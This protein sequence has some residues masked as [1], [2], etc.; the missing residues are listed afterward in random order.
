MVVRL[1]VAGLLLALGA[2][3]A[4]AEEL[5]KRIAITIDD[6]PRKAGP[7]MD[8]ECRTSLL[9]NSLEA[10]GITGA[11]FFV[12]TGGLDARGEEGDTRLKRYIEAG[13]VIANHTHGHGSANRMSAEDFIADVALAKHKLSAYPNAPYFRFPYLREGDNPAKRDAIRDGLEEL[14]LL[15]GYVTVDNYDWYLQALLDEAVRANKPLDLDAWREVYVE[16][17]TTEI[18][19]YDNIAVDALGRSPAHVL[20]LHE[21][22]LAALFIDDLAAALRADGWE[23]I[24]ALEAYE[25]PIAQTTPDTML[26]NQGRVSA[27]AHIAG[28]PA[29][30]LSHPWESRVELRALLVKRG[31]VD[32]AEG[33]YLEQT[34]PGI[35]PEVFA[36]GIV[37]LDDRYEFGTTLSADG[38]EIFFGTAI[39]D[40]GEIWN[41]RH[42]D[43]AWTTPEVMLSNPEYPYADPMLSRDRTRL[44]FISRRPV[45]GDNPN[46]SSDIWYLQWQSDGWSE[47]KHLGAPINTSADEF[48]VSF[49]DDG[50]FVFSSNRHEPDGTNFDL[51]LSRLTGDGFEEPQALQGNALTRAYEADPFIA[52][53]GSYI[54]FSSTR[55]SGIG[56][57]DIY[58]TFRQDDGSWSRSVNLGD[59]VNT[60]GN[61]FCPFVTRDGRF[62]F[63]TSNEDIFWVDAAVIEIARQLLR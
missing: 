46:S 56:G 37:S 8:A 9:I 34:S 60:S 26:L 18:A 63:Y 59:G 30:E 22:D 1:L 36:P 51:Y 4:S 27:L 17:L 33:A 43:G 21:N 39:D 35:V 7:L 52:P 54:L 25:D 40:R 3:N 55:R 47:P 14:G 12:T 50:E 11:M 58:A 13:H 49:T 31:M 2:M 53:D 20:L 10:A 16:V 57:R 45:D 6:A 24:P 44:Y 62:L 5:S 38:R 32:F 41:S 29:R 48:F 61:D 15:Q 42:T 23:I 19:H 28:Y